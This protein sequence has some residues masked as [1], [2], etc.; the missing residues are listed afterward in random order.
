V[1]CL[2]ENTIAGFLENHLSA[3]EQARI[4]EHLS[5]CRACRTIVVEAAAAGTRHPVDTGATVPAADILDAHLGHRLARA[6]AQKRIGTTLSGKWTID[7]LVGV[8][9][10]AFVFAATHRNGRRVAIKM[11][12]PELAALPALVDRFLREGYVANRV[13]HPGAVAVLDDDADGDGDPF[14][15]MELLEGETLRDRLARSGPMPAAEALEVAG[16][17]L[18]VLAAAHAKG[19]VHRD[20]KPDNLFRTTDGEI[21]VLDFGIARLRDRISDRAATRSGLTMG[22][23]GFMSPEQAR[24]QVD[25]VDARSDVW[26]A[27]A[28]LYMLLTGE[29]V[30]RAETTNEALLLAM[31]EAV[32][33]V[34][35]RAPALGEGVARLLDRA[36]AFDPSERFADAREMQQAV[37]RTA[38][39]V[40]DVVP[41]AMEADVDRPPSRRN[42]RAAAAFGVV[43]VACLTSLVAVTQA[44]RARGID[45]V[46]PSPSTTLA[47]TPPSGA[48]AETPAPEDAIDHV[49][50]V[51]AAPAVK[52][53]RSAATPNRS[54][55]K[56]RAVPSALPP[57][58][59]P[60]AASPDWLGPRL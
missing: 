17:F 4:D 51:E 60:P 27:G 11:M 42:I 36:L 29:P 59:L 15:V 31:T 21:K 34:R 28:T 48:R 22:T 5:A 23:V 40:R 9:G 46:T 10:M 38:E 53:T 25:R 54:L 49:V 3:D 39:G 45:A 20:V 1:A 37:R 32:P 44:P 30:H 56:L 33:P 26:A 24:G 8:G 7:R 58:A 57:P 13:A 16:Q 47:A 35:S 55:A 12:L 18:D 14:L 2:G 50:K 6:Q 19:I 52:S 43:A 41:D